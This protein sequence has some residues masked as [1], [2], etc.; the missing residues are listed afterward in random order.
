M[1]G[2]L[3]RAGQVVEK[4]LRAFDGPLTEELLRHPGKFGLGQVPGRLEPDAVATSICGF[5]S[6]GCSLR[7]HLQEGEAVNLT[8]DPVYPVNKGMACPKGWE[9]LAPLSASDRLTTPMY[10]PS[11]DR[12]LEPISWEEAAKVFCQRMREVGEAHGPEANAFL[13]T[14]QICV[15][16]MALLGAFAKFEMGIRHGDGNT[17]QCMATSVSAYKQ[18]FGF[19]A[20]PYTYKDFEESD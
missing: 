12:P 20:P 2:I 5:C 15:E 6:T 14:G 13:S 3:D 16:E 4:R 9:S 11:R 19:D 7:L 1:K 8:P 10:R 18:S 17:R